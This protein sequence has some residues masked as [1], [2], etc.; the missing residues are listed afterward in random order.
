MLRR[1]EDRQHGGETDVAPLHDLAPLVAGLG[2]EHLVQFV[3][4]VHPL[5]LVHLRAEAVRIDAGLLHQFGVELRLDGADADV[6]AVLGLVG[7]VEVRA[8]VAHVRSALVLEA[9]ASHGEEHGHQGRGTVHHRG[10]DD[11]ALA[12]A[13][14]LQ[15]AADQ[16]VGEQH[17]A[18][19][20]V[21]DEV[22][23]RH[24]LAAGLANRSQCA[25]QADVVDVVA[26]GV[27]DRSFLAPA[28]HAAVDELLVARH[29]VVG[30]E[31]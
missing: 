3:L 18:A 4:E 19:A 1:F 30:T 24:R 10:V 12:G 15:Q 25:C 17:A 9:P 8:A 13:G 29:A 21:A 31:A 22:E 16:P 2:L 11:L 27:G 7:V 20:E 26:G 6:L 14:R 5:I 23:R 28:G